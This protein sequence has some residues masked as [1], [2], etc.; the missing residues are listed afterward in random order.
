MPHDHADAE[1]A[2]QAAPRTT[3]IAQC[4]RRSPQEAAQLLEDHP[5]ET[6]TAVL[7]GLGPDFRSDIPAG[8]MLLVARH[9]GYPNAFSLAA[10]VWLAL[11]APAW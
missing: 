8:G 6:I 7:A 11:S 4:K 10:V 1:A 9:Q 3:P 5:P 2:V